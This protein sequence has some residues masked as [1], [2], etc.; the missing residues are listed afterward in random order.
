MDT[1]LY[2]AL[3]NH[4]KLNRSSFH[5]P[6]HK[7]SGIVNSKL[8][9][10]DYTELPDT[11]ALFE[12][13]GV[14]LESEKNLAKLF[15]A[16]R[17]LISAGGCSL[18]IMTMIRLATMNGG[19]LLCGRNIHRSAVNAMTLLGVEPIWILPRNNGVFTGRI[20][21]EDVRKAL[22]EIPDICGCYI[23][24]PTY[25]GEISDITAI[26]KVCKEYN[27]P[28]LVD[29]AHGSHLKFLSE[30]IHPITLGASMTACSVHK[31]LP[32]LTGGALLNINDDRFIEGAKEAMS[33]FASTSPP[34]PIM[35]SIDLC[36][37][38]IYKN[39]D[40]Y[41]K[42]ESVI[43]EIKT[44]ADSL[45]IVQPE[46]L[47]DPLRIALNTASIGISGESAGE[48]FRNMGVE[49]EMTDNENV[50]F[51][52]TPFNSENDFVRLKKAIKSLI[53]LNKDFIV[54]E[55]SEI[56]LPKRV[57]SLREA[58]LGKS[59]FIPKEKAV[60][61]ISADTACP[62]PPG[63][64]VYM[65]GEIIESYDCLNDFVKVLV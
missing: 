1:P 44:L 55:K 60:G 43:A 26:S 25:Y 42:L 37:D 61:R 10:L 9:E 3:I 40:I 22:A 45:G 36:A 2:N 39:A 30:D 49:P 12:A 6:G 54:K 14:I 58:V 56:S 38:Y 28:L 19:K 11:D 21:A 48:F 59:E 31:T 41:K 63:I 46:G 20:Y 7:S 34:Y 32:V 27:I 62:C 52:C 16:K 50:V 15:G 33:L 18:A 65:P 13:N 35:A 24:S 64:P 23:T 5:T 57:M 4:K 51:I 29:N 47:C 8:L 17:T 53:T